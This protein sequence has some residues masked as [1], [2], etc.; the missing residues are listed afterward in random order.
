MK[1]QAAK[2]SRTKR[3]KFQIPIGDWADDGH[4]KVDWVSAKAS[5]VDI[6][7]VREAYF[8]GMKRLKKEHPD[9]ASPEDLYSDY[10]S[11]Q[12]LGMERK[13]KEV[14]GLDIDTES[15]WPEGLRS[16]DDFASYVIWVI[17]FGNPEMKCKQISESVP[18]L[19][20]YGFDKK[21]RHIGFFGYGLFFD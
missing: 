6:E 13:I 12:D 7:E 21:K 15:E 20:F 17:N 4:G 14:T 18:T 16:S 9:I 10:E 8:A 19:P 11:T 1:K 5:A 3:L 2:K